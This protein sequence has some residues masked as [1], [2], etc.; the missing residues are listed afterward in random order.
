MFKTG[1]NRPNGLIWL[2][3]RLFCY[4]APPRRQTEP[5]PSGQSLISRTTTTTFQSSYECF[6][7]LRRQCL[8]L[9]FCLET[10]NFALRQA[11]H[12]MLE[13]AQNDKTYNTNIRSFV[14]LQNIY[15]G[16][17][18][19]CLISIFYTIFDSSRYCTPFYEWTNER[20]WNMCLS[21]W[22]HHS[23]P[24]IAVQL[25]A[26]HSSRGYRRSLLKHSY[27][28]SILILYILQGRV[29]K[30]KE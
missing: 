26:L 13:L 25:H 19:K 18:S 11:S 5:S 20:T 27:A 30:W 12:G 16:Q 10:E 3:P 4:S 6:T 9:R 1:L 14:S 17:I 22:F 28:M 15:L 2:K 29:G 21:V 8:A 7:L 24:P 23:P